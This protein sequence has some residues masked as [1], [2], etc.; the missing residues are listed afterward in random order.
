MA[1]IDISCKDCE[2]DYWEIITP[3]VPVDDSEL[4]DYREE[5]VPQPGPSTFRTSG[6]LRLSHTD[7]TPYSYPGTDIRSYI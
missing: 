3:A 6:L 2:Y 4:N 1:T 7:K 5:D